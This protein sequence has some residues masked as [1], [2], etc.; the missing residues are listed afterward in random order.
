MWG[1]KK[2]GPGILKEFLDGI[3]KEQGC[4]GIAYGE[5]DIECHPIGD[6]A[7]AIEMGRDKIEGQPEQDLYQGFR[8]EF[9]LDEQENDI[10]EEYGRQTP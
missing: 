1:D 7:V 2:E 3:H 9:G 10:N 8:I 5:E 6:D 4:D